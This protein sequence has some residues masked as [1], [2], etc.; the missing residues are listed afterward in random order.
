VTIRDRIQRRVMPRLIVRL[1]RVRWHRRAAAAL[2]RG[3]GG[4]GT[5]RL[6]LAF[7]DASS[8]IAMLGLTDRLAGR[9]VRL[10]VEP[11]VRRGIPGDPAEPDKRRY[12]V[13]DARRL[14]RRGGLEL[15]R[16]EPVPA[17]EAAFLAEWATALPAGPDRNG[18][19][20]DAMRLLWL[21]SDGALPVDDLEALWSR[22]SAALPPAANGVLPG[23][24]QMK[25]RRLYDTPVAVVHGRWYFAH[26]RLD[27]IG[28]WLDELGWTASP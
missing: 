7:D 4:R 14:A 24:R 13:V 19:C 9:R 18:F 28:E 20:V 17:A 3:L 10:L 22:R 6:F 16:S 21:D 2:R 25:R 1:S 15:S 5:V 11:V 8:A 27:Q 23:E 26:E 12:A